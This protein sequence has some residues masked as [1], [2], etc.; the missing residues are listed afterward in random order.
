[1]CVIAVQIGDKIG[2]GLL[3]LQEIAH[4]ELGAECEIVAREFDVFLPQVFG[5]LVQILVVNVGK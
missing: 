5:V 3:Q 1:M 4:N 2:V